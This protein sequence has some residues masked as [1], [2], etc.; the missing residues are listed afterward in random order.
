MFKPAGMENHHQA[1]P[2]QINQELKTVVGYPLSVIGCRLS[3]IGYR[4]SVIK[5]CMP[6]DN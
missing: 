5:S 1:G 6:T 2:E 4:L 3:V